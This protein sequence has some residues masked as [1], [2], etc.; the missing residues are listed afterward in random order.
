M[1]NLS[2]YI[3]EKA[4]MERKAAMDAEQARLDMLARNIEHVNEIVSFATS[5]DVAEE[6]VMGF[7]NSEEGATL[8]SCIDK[9]DLYT[10]KKLVTNNLCRQLNTNT[11]IKSNNAL[12]WYVSDSLSMLKESGAI[13]FLRWFDELEPYVGMDLVIEWIEAYILIMWQ[14]KTVA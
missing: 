13:T 2:N 1:R 12:Y 6:F 4:A 11:V 5:R 10:A 14:I 7:L 8:I 3:A 9:C